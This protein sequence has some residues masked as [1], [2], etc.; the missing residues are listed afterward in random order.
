MHYWTLY[1]HITG[2]G[3][4]AIADFPKRQDAEAALI[5]F[6]IQL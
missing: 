3:V 1:D 5:R 4:K 2:A 6:S